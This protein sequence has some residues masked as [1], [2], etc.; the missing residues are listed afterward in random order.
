MALL[1]KEQK[2]SK[3]NKKIFNKKSN[4]NKILIHNNKNNSPF[5]KDHYNN[6]LNYKAI[7]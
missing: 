4:R 6:L 5:N 2:K 1:L 3:F 7:N